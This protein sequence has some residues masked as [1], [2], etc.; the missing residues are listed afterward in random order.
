VLAVVRRVF[1][2]AA[3]FWVREHDAVSTICEFSA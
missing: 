3:V 2:V 1:G